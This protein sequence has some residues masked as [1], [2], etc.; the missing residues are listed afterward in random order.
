MDDN[1][2]EDIFSTKY[3]C[4][5][6][7]YTISELEPKLFSFNSQAGACESCDGLGIKEYFD[8]HKI[9]VNPELS[10]LKGAIYGW[11]DKSAYYS[12]LLKSLAE[13][14]KIDINIAYRNLSDSFKKILFYGSG[15]EV[16]KM[17]YVRGYRKKDQ[18]DY[19]VKEEIWDG[20][21]K[22]FAKQYDNGSY[23]SKDRYQNT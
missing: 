20:I 1:K 21:L 14:Y 7:G 18:S 15:K 12:L 5:H 23:S 8:P 9:I 13:H 3:S 22:K 2:I 11:D 19:V 10:L 4:P 6:C 17:K 16:I